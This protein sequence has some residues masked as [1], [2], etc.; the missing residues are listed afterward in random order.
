MW[1]GVIVLCPSVGYLLISS[2]GPPVGCELVTK[3]RL[4]W[5][6]PSG[7]SSLC[8]ERSVPVSRTIALWFE[9]LPLDRLIR[10]CDEC[11]TVFFM[12]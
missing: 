3:L 1:S 9:K 2:V 11:I 6:Y 8:S 10:M 5:R 12:W 7:Y 4:R